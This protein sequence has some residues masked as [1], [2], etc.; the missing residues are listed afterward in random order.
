M[1]EA[2]PGS[3][4]RSGTGELDA[5]RSALAAC[6]VSAAAVDTLIG[7]LL[8]S[9]VPPSA[10][11]TKRL[12][13]EADRVGG[14][15]DRDYAAR[16]LQIASRN[17]ASEPIRRHLLDLAMTRAQGFAS[18]A[19]AGGE[20]MARMLHVREIEAERAAAGDP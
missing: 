14:I 6:G 13:Q 1:A 10:A 11:L 18:A 20:G 16:A 4:L 15:A 3:A 17:A 5:C 9:S 12:H 2:H 8:R 7:E 19:T